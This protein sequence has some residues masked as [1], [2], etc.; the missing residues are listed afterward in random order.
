LWLRY[1][2]L[3]AFS[4]K[5]AK[6]LRAAKTSGQ[7]KPQGSKNLRAAKTSVQQKPNAFSK[8]ASFTSSG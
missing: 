6:N 4:K 2:L 5:R 3:G 7:Q 8:K 1:Q